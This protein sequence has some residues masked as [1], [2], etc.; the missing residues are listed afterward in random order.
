MTDFLLL[1]RDRG[2][3]KAITDN[4]AGGLSSSVGEMAKEIGCELHLDRAPLK[5][6][7]LH[8]WEVLLSEAQERMTLAVSPSKIDVFL[9][10]AKKMDVEATVLGTF[11]QTKKFHVLYRGKTVAYLDMDFLHFGLPKME[12]RAKWKRPHHEEAGFPEPEDLTSTL[13][14]MLSRLNICSKESMIRQYDHEVQGGT[15]IK[16]LVGRF[17]DGPSDAAVLRPILDSF[18]GIVISNGICPRYSDIDAYA[19]TACAI[20]EAIRNNVAVG[21]N[22]DRIAGLDNF[23]WPDPVQSEKAPDGEYKLALLVRTNQALYDYCKVFGVPLI[24]GKDSMK[25]DYLIGGTKISIPPT[26][27]I[28]ALGKIDDVR[29]A[30]TM[31][32]KR[33]GDLVYILGE[34]LDELGGSEYYASKGLIGNRVPWVDAE[35][36]R[37]LYRKIYSAIQ[38]GLIRSCHDCSDG[39][40]GVALAETAFA[41]GFGMEIDLRKVPRTGLDRNDFLLFSE[42]QSRFIV[43]ID[44]TKKSAFEA[45]LGDAVYGEIGVVTDDEIFR[46]V[47]LH[48]KTVVEA[49]IY[50]LKEVWQKTLRF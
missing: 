4:G 7:G 44:P 29:K 37:S 16:P 1:A 17:N 20:D 22:P 34:T 27:L 48:G 15:V 26:I 3:F 40:L 6:H 13:K 28:S 33:P 31:D 10:L 41:G 18:E 49:N 45:L 9:Q 36:A 8:P 47:G 32:V 35:K 50:N 23:C 14:E 11:T 42:S 21:G 19:M 5:Y 38:G 30:I 24:S 43:T 46:M 25:N 39:G 12:L 2:L